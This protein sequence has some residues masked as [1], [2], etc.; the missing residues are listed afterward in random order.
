MTSSL[1]SLKVTAGTTVISAL[2]LTG[3]GGNDTLAG[4]NIADT[5]TGGVGADSLLGAGGSDIFVFSVGDSNAVVTNGN[6]NDT[7]QD[8]LHD[9]VSGDLIRLNITSSDTTWNMAHVLVGTTGGTTGVGAVN[10]Y[11]ANTYLVQVGDPTSATDNFD[12]AIIAST[13]GSTAAF[14]NAAAAQAATVVNLTG[15]T[16]ADSLTGGA[17]NDTI[18]GGDGADSIVGGGGGDSLVGGAGN[19]IYLIENTD[20]GTI[21]AASGTIFNADSTIATATL[22][23]ITFLVGDTLKWGITTSL[24]TT[25]GTVNAAP[26][27]GK[28][29]LVKGNYTAA[30]PTTGAVELFTQTTS[31]TSTMVVWDSDI[32]TTNVSYRAVI[33]VG[34]TDTGTTDPVGTT[35]STGLIGTA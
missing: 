33:L 35:G 19:D 18:T 8:V 31:G 12:I 17:N 10:G 22:D 7:G 1:S 30:V 11:L 26:G 16:G 20:S 27:D 4:G 34:Y 15:T 14:A 5:I 28:F 24:S 6:A 2:S 32:S 23:K 21:S 3:G 29:S 25:L 9:W 13:D